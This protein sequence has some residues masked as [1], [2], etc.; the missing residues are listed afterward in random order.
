[1]PYDHKRRKDKII[2]QNITKQAHLSIATHL[3]DAEYMGRY[4]ESGKGII[5]SSRQK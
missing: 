5:L 4:V 2:S 1:M 3:I